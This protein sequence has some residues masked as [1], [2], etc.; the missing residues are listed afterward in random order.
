MSLSCTT[1]V[2]CLCCGLRRH[3]LPS[4]PSSRFSCLEE[5]P[6]SL[7]PSP[8]AAGSGRCILSHQ[9]ALRCS[10]TILLL[11][12]QSMLRSLHYKTDGSTGQ[13]KHVECTV[14]HRLAD[15]PPYFFR[16]GVHGDI[17]D[18]PSTHLFHPGEIF[19]KD[20]ARVN[21]H[22]ICNDCV[23]NEDEPRSVYSC[24]RNS[25]NQVELLHTAP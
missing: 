17:V 18:Q 16:C 12:G 4:T 22:S 25:G 21:K 5:V 19:V 6:M 14:R 13:G 1:Y 23:P 11:H 20:F 9:I 10:L 3:R 7:R 2:A 24:A 15:P 8:G